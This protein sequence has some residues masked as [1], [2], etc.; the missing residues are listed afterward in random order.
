MR[1]VLDTNTVVYFFMGM[2]DV[3]ARLAEVPPSAVAIPSVVLYEL[4]TGI[5]KSSRPTRRREQLAALTRSV[6][7]LPFADREERAAAEIRAALERAGTP[8]GPLDTL[9]AGT[10]VANGGTLVTRNIQ[11]FGRVRGLPVVDWFTP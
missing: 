1:F 2:G 11:E 7:L 6:A 5:A 9:I 8:I 10:A 3:A 4:E